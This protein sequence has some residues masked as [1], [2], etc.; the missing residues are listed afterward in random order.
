LEAPWLTAASLANAGLILEGH[1]RTW[2]S[3]LLALRPGSPARLQAQE[4]FASATVVL[5]HDG[6]DDPRLIYANRA[7]LALWRRDWPTMVGLPSRLTAE[8]TERQARS[9]ALAEALRQGGMSG[10]GGIRI[11]SEGRRFRIA[12]ARLWSLREG[13][14]KTCGQ[15]ACF[16]SWWWI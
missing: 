4:L 10:Y 9:G 7:A 5:A 2:G 16:E 12:A 6:A 1:R 15:A 13:A 8:P 14:G 3:P 11:D